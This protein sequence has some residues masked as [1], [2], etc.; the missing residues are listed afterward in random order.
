MKMLNELWEILCLMGRQIR[1][2]PQTVICTVKQR[3]HKAVVDE[4]EAERLDRIRNPS[5]YR[6]K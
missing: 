1:D 6:G 3:K 5:K 4:Q 2:L